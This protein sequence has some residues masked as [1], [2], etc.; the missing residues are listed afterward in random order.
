[1]NVAASYCFDLKSEVTNELPDFFQC[2]GHV[3]VQ[4]PREACQSLYRFFLWSSEHDS[5]S[6][7]G[8]HF[9]YIRYTYTQWCGSHVVASS[10]YT[11]RCKKFSP[12]PKN[13]FLLTTSQIKQYLVCFCSNFN[14]A[15]SDRY[16]VDYKCI[17]RNIQT[18]KQHRGHENMYQKASF[19]ISIWYLKKA[20]I[21]PVK[22][23]KKCRQK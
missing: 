22:C 10:G 23:T 16:F 14:F 21:K 4:L 18:V 17:C 5:R 19:I 11:I 15:S 8:A 7:A 2:S 1:M 6:L 20:L 13:H 9:H 12:L 3:V